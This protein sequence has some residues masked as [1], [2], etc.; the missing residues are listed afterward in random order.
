LHSE[1]IRTLQHQLLTQRPG[2]ASFVIVNCTDT[3]EPD[4][5]LQT[6]VH[7]W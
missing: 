5:K 2:P 6:V 3:A 4:S 7:T 1:A